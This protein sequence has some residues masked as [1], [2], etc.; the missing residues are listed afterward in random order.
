MKMLVAP[1][2]ALEISDPPT[3]PRGVARSSAEG[4]TSFMSGS[5]TGELPTGDVEDL[6]VDEVRPRRAEEEDAAGGLLGRA[7]ASERDEQRRHLPKLLGDAELH[8]LAVDLHRVVRFLCR[9]QT[10]VD[11]AE[12]NGVDVDLELAPLLGQRLGQADDGGL[13][14]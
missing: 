13:A 9:R 14:G 4:L 11:E 2:V 6:P 1:V 12:R 3:T 7:G 8:G 5:H 10:R